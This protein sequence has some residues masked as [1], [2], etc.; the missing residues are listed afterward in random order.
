MF[1]S[2]VCEGVLQYIL[3][4]VIVFWLYEGKRECGEDG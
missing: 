4:W 2:M 1:F 3:I